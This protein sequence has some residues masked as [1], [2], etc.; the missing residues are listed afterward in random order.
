MAHL[1]VRRFKTELK[2]NHS[3]GGSGSGTSTATTLPSGPISSTGAYIPSSLRRHHIPVARFSS[4]EVNQYC[5]NTA[6]TCL[7]GACGNGF[8]ETAPAHPGT[9]QQALLGDGHNQVL[10]PVPSDANHKFQSKRG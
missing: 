8:P 5:H 7:G 10:P 3:C 1:K 4:F 2:Y 9:Y 6:R